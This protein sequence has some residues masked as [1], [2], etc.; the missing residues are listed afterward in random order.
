MHVD[1]PL[2]VELGG[3]ALATAEVIK[4]SSRHFQEDDGQCQISRSRVVAA[5]LLM[6][7]SQLWMALVPL[8]SLFLLTLDCACRMITGDRDTGAAAA[9]LTTEH[10]NIF[11][12]SR[13]F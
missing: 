10:A 1:V 7:L 13:Y 3:E 5:L 12:E 11:C 6:H 9:E 4:I 8:V 2:Q